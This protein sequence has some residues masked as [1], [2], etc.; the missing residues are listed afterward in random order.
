M[1][2]LDT[3]RLGGETQAKVKRLCS[4]CGYDPTE[5]GCEILKACGYDVTKHIKG[6]ISVESGGLLLFFSD[7][8]DYEG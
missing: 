8:P 5:I 3:I 4:D 6:D 1:H 7:L 2:I